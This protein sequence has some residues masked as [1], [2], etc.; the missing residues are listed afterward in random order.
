MRSVDELLA[1]H[2]SSPP[3]F[4]IHLYPEHWTLNNGSKFLYNN[5]VAVRSA[6]CRIGFALTKPLSRCSM[7]SER[8]GYLQTFWSYLTLQT[9]PFTMVSVCSRVA[10]FTNEVMDCAGC[11]IV[12]LLDYRPVK[13]KDPVLVNPER[14]RVVL[15]PN[16]E[17]LWADLCLMNVK[18]ENVWTDRDA[19]EVEARIL[20]RI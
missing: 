10:I 6:A 17:T 7:I 12:E 8:R 16:S 20:V 2:K 4:T 18:A 9:C 13:A 11:M 14:S 19:L 5:Q 15:T 3:S 1:Q